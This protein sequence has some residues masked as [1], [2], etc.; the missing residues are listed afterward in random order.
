MA[1]SDCE[2]GLRIAETAA[3]LKLPLQRYWVEDGATFAAT[4][5]QTRRGRDLGF[6]C[7]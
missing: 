7:F 5:M 6:D 4:Q 1:V 3:A 2:D